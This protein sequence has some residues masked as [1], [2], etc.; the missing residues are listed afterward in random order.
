[1]TVVGVSR[2]S[3]FG[4]IGEPPTPFFYVP[5]RQNFQGD[6]ILNVRSS[7]PPAA[8]GKM[9]ER[10]VRVLDP[11][12]VHYET[13]TMRQIVER[14]AS[15]QRVAVRL[16]EI[17][18]AL[19]LLLAAIGLFGVLSYAV[20][21]RTREL[22]VRMALGARRWDLLRLVAAQGL[23]LTGVG[24]L[25]GGLAALASTRLLG[26]LL[27]RVSPRDPSV[28][29]WAALTMLATALAACA[30]PA[31]RAMRLDPWKALRE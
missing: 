31:V 22:G 14:S 10:E 3:E 23:T 26:N 1:M 28:F 15:S 8:A 16:L 13:R 18:G 27:Y 6:A 2:T 11:N 9:I 12:L 17:F 21:Q 25:A 20:S 19:A 29:T 30:W 4:K 5:I 24:V 7:Y